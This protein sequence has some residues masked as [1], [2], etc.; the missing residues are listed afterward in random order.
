MAYLD[1]NNLII[2]KTNINLK[3]KKGDYVGFIGDKKKIK[4]LFLSLSGINKTKGSILCEDKNIYDNY[5][6]FKNRIIMDFKR[7][8]VSTLR[9]DL[10]KEAFNNKFNLDIDTDLFIKKVNGMAIRKEAFYDTK[11]VFTSYGNTILNYCLSSSISNKNM[12]IINPFYKINND[13]VKH[14]IAKDLS[15]RNNFNSLLIDANDLLYFNNLDYYI[16]L[17]KEDIVKLDFD[18][19]VLLFYNDYKYH[20][21]IYKTNKLT[22]CLN[23]YTK[24]EIKELSKLKLDYRKI[25]FKDIFKYLEE[26]KNAKK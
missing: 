15:I 16:F 26:E 25:K 13:S 22:V 21:V 19:D 12:M 24:E 4:D 14:D 10:I 7:T 17:L 2:D 18:S 1:I 5:D 11:Y 9:K 6:Y 8:Y 3:I 23:T 20:D